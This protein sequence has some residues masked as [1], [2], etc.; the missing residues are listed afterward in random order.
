MIVSAIKALIDNLIV[1]SS[2][3]CAGRDFF[4]SSGKNRRRDQK[5]LAGKNR[6]VRFAIIIKLQVVLW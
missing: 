2:V 6:T 1:P 5:S 4:R 3:D